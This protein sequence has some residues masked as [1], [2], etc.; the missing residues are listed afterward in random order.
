MAS[1]NPEREPTLFE[2]LSISPKSLEGQDPASQTKI[3]R[4]AYRR[5]L[6]KHHPDR[7]AQANKEN[8]AASSD[9]SSSTPSEARTQR[10]EHYTVDQITEAY[11]VLSDEKKRR[12][13]TRTLHSQTRTTASSS[14][15]F[16]TNPKRRRKPGAAASGVETV[17]LDTDLSWD[18]KR[19]L[20]Y[21]ACD[22]CGKARG[23]GLRE[24][25]IEDETDEEVELILKCSGCERGLRVIV[26]ALADEDDDQGGVQ[27]G[28]WGM[29]AQQQPQMQTQAAQNPSPEPPKKKKGWGLSLGLGLGLS[30]GGGGSA[31]AGS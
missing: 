30:L 9:S 11:D 21:R 23:F 20:Y 16:S 7:Q 17:D 6:L 14:S 15:T 24:D 5:A 12:K 13:Y 10:E 2:V 19:R 27:R 1:T 18:G 31:R 28:G 22:G 25:G 8:D 3:T 26:P 29:A 4:Q